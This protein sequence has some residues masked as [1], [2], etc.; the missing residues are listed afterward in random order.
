M[1]FL[2]THT[3]R[4]KSFLASLNFNADIAGAYLEGGRTGERPPKLSKIVATRSQILRLQC[5]KFNFG[6]P[7]PTRELTE[8][9]DNGMKV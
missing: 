3:H 5:T 7:D 6:A 9:T 4:E 1:R 8:I 2:H